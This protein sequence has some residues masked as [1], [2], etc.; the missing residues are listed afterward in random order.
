[1]LWLLLPA[2]ASVT[3]LAT[4]N[5]VC[6]DV[7]VVPFLWVVPLALYLVT[8]IVA[9]DH[10][11]WYRPTLIAAGTLAAIYG[12]AMV[13]HNGIGTIDLYDCASTGRL[14]RMV[15]QAMIAA[16]ADASDAAPTSPQFSVSFRQF[17]ALNLA[18]MFGI[19]LL[20]HGELARQRPHPRHLTS[21]YLA[22]AAGGALGGVA[23]TLVAPQL[24]KTYLEWRIV[25]LVGA[26]AA[27]TQLLYA[28]LGRGDDSSMPTG[29][30][31]TRWKVVLLVVLLAPTTLV[32]VDLVE[33]LNSSNVGVVYRERDFFG[34]LVI[35]ERNAGDPKSRQLVLQH[36]VTTHGTQF[37]D[38]SRRGIPTS[39]YS[40]PSGVGRTLNFFRELPDFS[41][42]K[43]GAVGL[44]TGTLAAYVGEGDSIRFY[45]VNPA[46]VE[47]AASGRWFHYLPD[48]RAR[49]GKY[50]IKLGDARLSLQRELREPDPP[51]YHVLVLDAFSGDA[52]PA[53]LL[54]EEAFASY[55]EHL[56]TT[57]EDGVEGALAVHISN[58]YLNLDPVVRGAAERFGLQSV[59]IHNS[60]NPAYSV[61]GA[62]WVI[63]TNNQSLL[64]ALTPHAAPASERQRP[65]ILW[66]DARSNLFDVLK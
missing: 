16:V 59:L 48:C 64:A 40:T 32:L 46:V 28:T 54:T 27:I 6:T 22:L 5:H 56:T 24:F 44:G 17:L 35:R 52:V 50:E 1:M 12:A 61:Y 37:T 63:L 53:H 33:Y 7:A 65:A 18:A 8:F 55:L 9:F 38:L 11:R 42:L 60:R 34:T 45:D 15:H 47:I 29:R 58:R 43:V 19:C 30:A 62:D 36:G 14:G 25:M 66:T 4:T 57:D 21:Y 3:L 51:R 41:S 23:V 13:A 31:F 26:I 20:C 49:G 10:P 2:F 39:Y